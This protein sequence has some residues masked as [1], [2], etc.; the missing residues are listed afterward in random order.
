MPIKEGERVYLRLEDGKDLLKVE[1]G[2][3]FS[4]HLGNIYFDH[5]IGKSLEKKFTPV[6]GKGLSLT[7]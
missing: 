5:I 4:T 3:F 2:K 6:K 1:K 7:A